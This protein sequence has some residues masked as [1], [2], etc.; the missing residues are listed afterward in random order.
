[1]RLLLAW[2]DALA[3]PGVTI[4]DQGCVQ[5]ACS[6]A[7]QSGASDRAA[8]RHVLEIL[9]SASLLVRVSAPS[10]EL[11]K[12][13]I[14][15][16][17]RQ[18]LLERMLERRVEDSLAFIPVIEE[19]DTICHTLGRRVVSAGFSD[20]RERQLNVLRIMDAVTGQLSMLSNAESLG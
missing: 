2:R 19:L 10:V 12:E 20:D 1:M 17:Q 18:G 15:R 13:L 7:I 14:A 16:R 4:F 11:E 3:Y 9:P 8:L 6:L 5:A